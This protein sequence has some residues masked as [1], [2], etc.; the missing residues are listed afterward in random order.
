MRLASNFDV[1]I[2]DI[3][4]AAKLSVVGNEQ[5]GFSSGQT[6]PTNGLIIAGNTGVGT[7]TPIANFQVADG[8]NA[9]TTMELGSAGQNK[10]SCLKLYRTDG[11]SIYA[12]V[13]AGATIFTLTTTSCANVTNF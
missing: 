2:N 9:T 10:G 8:S 7:S 6:A 1:G 12:Y 11:S 5:V 3:A 13:A 4:P